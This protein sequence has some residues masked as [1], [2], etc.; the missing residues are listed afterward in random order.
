M[1][2]EIVCERHEAKFFEIFLLFACKKVQFGPQNIIWGLK[3][4]AKGARAPP[5]SATDMPRVS[6]KDLI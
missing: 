2:I 4:G 1:R 5:G 6:V 3:N